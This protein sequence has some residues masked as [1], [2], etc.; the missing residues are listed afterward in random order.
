MHEFAETEDY[1]SGYILLK[2][3][4]NDI[5]TTA[6]LKKTL[7]KMKRSIKQSYSY[8]WLIRHDKGSTWA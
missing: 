8:A 4:G 7:D 1:R 3:Q 6:Q 5:P 2:E